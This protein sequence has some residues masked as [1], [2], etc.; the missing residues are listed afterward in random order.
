MPKVAETAGRMGE[1][2]AA[3]YLKKNGYKIIG[4]NF[5][6]R[7]GELDIIAQDGE[8]Y[9]FVEV[10]LR[11]SRAFG[12]PI[13]SVTPHK[14]RRMTRAAQIYLLKKKL[15]VPVRFDVVEIIGFEGD[16][17]LCIKEIGV[18]KNAFGM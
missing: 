18:V 6:V 17:G 1:D 14:I 9:V 11:A 4:R 16:G 7:G 3:E 5:L 13:D 12:S 8:Y 10:K 15:D 2:A